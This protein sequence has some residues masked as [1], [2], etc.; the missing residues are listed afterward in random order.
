MDMFSGKVPGEQP[1]AYASYAMIS[2]LL[3]HLERSGALAPKDCNA[4]LDAA[5]AMILDDNNAGEI[6]ARQ[7][8]EQLRGV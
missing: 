1:A 7:L 4:V 2:A 3:G 5:L 8:V 6:E